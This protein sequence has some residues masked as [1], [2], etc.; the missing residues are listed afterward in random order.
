MLSFSDIFRLPSERWEDKSQLPKYS[1][2]YFLCANNR[3]L[4]IGKARDIR[5]RWKFHDRNQEA[6][7]ISQ[8]G[9]DVRIRYLGMSPLNPLDDKPLLDVERQMIRA[10][11]PVF[12]GS[13]QITPEK[14]VIPGKATNNLLLLNTPKKDEDYKQR[15]SDWVVEE[16]KS[17]NLTDRALEVKLG[18]SRT[19]LYLWRNKKISKKLGIENIQAIARYLGETEE[20]VRSRF[21]GREAVQSGEHHPSVQLVR[22]APLEALPYLLRAF[23]ARLEEV[24]FKENFFQQ[25]NSLDLASDNEGL[26]LS[27]ERGA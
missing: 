17:K 14:T 13:P 11:N 26:E 19:T 25:G 12:N 2:I 4:Y 20:Q 7:I 22:A 15:L 21:E 8:S 1:G 23:A 10:F 16:Q 24:S 6:K 3:I 18:V 5:Q 9:S 27:E